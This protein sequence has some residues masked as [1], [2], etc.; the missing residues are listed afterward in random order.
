VIEAIHLD[1][2][3]NPS[4]RVSGSAQFRK[5][6]LHGISLNGIG[7]VPRYRHRLVPFD[8]E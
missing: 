7:T 4:C 6:H 2:I 1:L 8:H 5:N 3:R